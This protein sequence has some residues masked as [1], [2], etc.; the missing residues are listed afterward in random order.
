M[1]F[2]D[3]SG[4]TLREL[5]DLYS[6]NVMD[7]NFYDV[8]ADQILRLDEK[9]LMLIY[10]KL[11]LNQ[12]RGAVYSLRNS[13]KDIES[14]VEFLSEILWDS[15]EDALT[16]SEAAISLRHLH[17]CIEIYDFYKL[18]RDDSEH[19]RSAATL[20]ASS[21]EGIRG[22]VLS[23]AIADSS[24]IVRQ[25]VLDIIDDNSYT[26]YLYLARNCL[27]DADADVRLAAQTA[28]DNNVL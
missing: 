16:R 22:E 2:L 8:I 26:E 12:K 9:Y 23:T 25:F 15:S 4:Y 5:T 11:S 18:Y 20:L 19:L 14:A 1:T 6:L 24:P 28:L 13:L 3:I 7:D 27:K 10:N 21:V 17:K